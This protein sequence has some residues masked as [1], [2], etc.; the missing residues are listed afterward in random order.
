GVPRVAAPVRQ[1]AGHLEQ[2]WE[3]WARLLLPRVTFHYSM[4]NQPAQGSN[5]GTEKKHGLNDVD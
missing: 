3:N 1:C 2:D 5:R 4:R